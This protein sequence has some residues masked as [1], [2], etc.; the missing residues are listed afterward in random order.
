MNDYRILMNDYRTSESARASLPPAITAVVIWTLGAALAPCL[1]V[2]GGI[3]SA[4]ILLGTGFLA[5]YHKSL[6]PLLLVQRS[7]LVFGFVAGAV[8]IAATYLLYPLAAGLFPGL[9]TGTQ[10]LYQL[11]NSGPG[12]VHLV[13]LPLVIVGEEVVWRGLFQTIAS[14]RLGAAGGVLVTALTYAAVHAPIG[15]PLLTLV[16]FCCGV[17]WSLIRARTNSL[18][19]GL[20]SHLAWDA[21]VM[22]LFPLVRI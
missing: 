12:L 7:G 18:L 19:P 20:V 15:A 4:A 14:R 1:G 2:W 17:Y 16:A 8:M 13:L 21:V 11:L 10:Q 3:G 5:S 6:Q 9:A 22:V